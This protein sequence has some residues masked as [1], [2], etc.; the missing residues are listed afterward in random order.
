MISIVIPTLNE[1]KF[2]PKL[3]DSLVAQTQ[4]DFEVVVVDGS[5]TDKTVDIAHSYQSKLL[6][7]TVVVSKKACLPLQRNL[8]AQRA[9]GEWLIFVDADSVLMPYFIDRVKVFIEK[10][11]PTWFTTWCLPDSNSV[12]DAIFTLFANVFWESMFIIKRP[13]A[14]GP[15][16]C[17]RRDLFRS[18]GGYNETQAFNED[19][20]FGL[21][22]NKH[23]A[24]LTF[25]RETLYIW[26]MRRIRQE[27]RMKLMNQYILSM[28][29]ILLFKRPFKVMPGYIMG[30]HLYD[31]KKQKIKLL[32]MKKYELQFKKFMK[33]FL[34]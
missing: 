16:N 14:P 2:L 26:S 4:T 19:V 11:S 15:L 10:T 12:N 9:S 32:S 33:E 29:P 22:L 21:R 8:G 27:G 25:L 6:K 1:E 34:E 23:G 28:I 20:E 18:V 5:S 7:L 13:V 24:T 30:G 3:L 31:K 17:I